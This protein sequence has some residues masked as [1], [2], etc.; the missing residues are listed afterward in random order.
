MIKKRDIFVMANYARNQRGAGMIIE[1]VLAAV[2]IA[3]VGLAF[4]QSKH[5]SAPTA[6]Q[7]KATLVEDASKAVNDEANKE[8]VLGDQ[9]EASADEAAGIDTDID[10]LGGSFDENSF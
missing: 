8:S 9:T 6:S 10:N 3:L 4:Y 7:T 1:L 2:V 5:G